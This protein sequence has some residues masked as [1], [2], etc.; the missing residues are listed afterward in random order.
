VNSPFAGIDL[1]GTTIGGVLADAAGRIVER[2]SIA[3]GRRCPE[4]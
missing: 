2:E 3:T 1:G 4:T